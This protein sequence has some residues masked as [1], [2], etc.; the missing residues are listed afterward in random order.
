MVRPPRRPGRDLERGILTLHGVTR[1]VTFDVEARVVG[2]TVVLATAEPV[3]VK[4]A[5]HGLDAPEITG[6]S[7][8]RGTGA[9][10]FLVVVRRP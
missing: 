7:K 3:A 2:E 10:E 9:F 4:L 6:V 8:V 5:D 1:S